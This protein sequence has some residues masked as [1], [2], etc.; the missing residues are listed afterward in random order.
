MKKLEL[1]YSEETQKQIN[2]N[3]RYH[4]EKFLNM[5]E[6]ELFILDHDLLGQQRDYSIAKI[7]VKR[8]AKDDKT[9]LTKVLEVIDEMYK[10]EDYIVL[11]DKL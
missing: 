9:V 11:Y 8:N 1:I 6:F 4:G 10:N 2:D 7:K 3:T 5:E